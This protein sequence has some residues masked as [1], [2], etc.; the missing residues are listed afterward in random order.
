MTLGGKKLN[1]YRITHKQL[2]DGRTLRMSL[3]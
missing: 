2:I 3:K 1:G